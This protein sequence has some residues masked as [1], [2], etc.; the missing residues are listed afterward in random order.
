[1]TAASTSSV[2]ATPSGRYTIAALDHRDAL[3]AEFER[4]RTGSPSSVAETPSPSGTLLS[5]T[6][7]SDPASGASALRRFKSDVLAAIGRA[8]VKPSAVMLEPEYSLPDL[9]GEVPDG[10]AVTC[11]LE[12][13]GYLDQPGA[14]NTLMEGWSPSRV[15]S[16]G[17]DG[18][19][20]LVLY[21]HD[22]GAFTEA[23][24]ALVA[25]VVAEAAEVGVPALIEPVP[26]EVGDAEDR[27]RV[28]VEAARRIGALGPMLLKLPFPGGG[29]ACAEVTEAAGPHPWILL[30]WGVTYDEF[31]AQLTEAMADGCSGFAV[32]RALWREAVDPDGRAGFLAGTFQD[33]LAELIDVVEGPPP[34]SPHLPPNQGD[35]PHV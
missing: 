8:P 18:A 28:I 35:H 10:V 26:V 23:Q 21:R 3:V 4:L 6:P 16:V 9:R 19:K 7:P 12:A 22:R 31:L 25:Q 15:G 33:R 14:G 13:Q 32:G 5:E 27:R 34:P 1:M 11:A 24:E 30:S 17:A 29:G 20:L 2:L